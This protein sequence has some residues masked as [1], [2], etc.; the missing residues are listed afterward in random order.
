MTEY[1]VISG[2][3]AVQAEYEAMRARGEGHRLAEMLATRVTPALLTDAV[4]MEG[5]CNGNQFEHVPAVG[6]RFRRRAAAAGVDPTGKFYAAGLAAF[7]GDPRAWV[8]GR[9]D[10][11]RVCEERGYECEGAV[12]YRPA[13]PRDGAPDVD[14]APDIVAREARRRAEKDPALALKD[15]GEL[16]H[17][18]REIHKPHWAK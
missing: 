4:F 2:D 18:T 10:V 1:P 6:D 8:S 16:R 7:P 17:E 11:R 12:R 13:V 3:P 9:G 5:R 14:L 15:P